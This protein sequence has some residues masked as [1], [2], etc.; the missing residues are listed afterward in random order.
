MVAKCQFL[1][2]AL[3]EPDAKRRQPAANFG[4]ALGNREPA[5]GAKESKMDVRSQWDQANVLSRS[6]RGSVVADSMS[7]PPH[8]SRF[9][10][11][12]EPSYFPCVFPQIRSSTGDILY[13]DQMRDNCGGSCNK[14]H[15]GIRHR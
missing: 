4:R 14:H 9:T 3:N 11:Q 10:C 12:S 13:E 15:L 5:S 8:R 1:K 6:V 7:S 2:T